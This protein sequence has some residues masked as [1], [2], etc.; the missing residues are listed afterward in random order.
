MAPVTFDDE[1]QIV[2]KINDLLKKIEKTAND[3]VDAINGW[4]NKLPDIFT[5]GIRAATEKFVDLMNRVF[6]AVAEIFTNLGSPATLWHTAD[7]W[8]A[9][10]GGPVSGLSG[11]ADPAQSA[12]LQRWTGTAAD[13]YKETL[14]PQRKAIDAIK[15][16]MT[17]PIS[18]ALSAVARAIWV[19]FAALITGF[20]AL[21]G[22]LIAALGSTAT[23]V[24]LPAA[25]FIAGA[26]ALVFI[27]A[28]YTAGQILRSQ[29]AD[30]NTT[31]VAKLNDNTAFRDGKWPVA[32]ANALTD[33]SLTDDDTDWH[34][35]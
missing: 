4:L 24:G 21:V 26:G 6:A 28:F 3:I 18:T 19:F 27:A 1:S 25:P 12:A 29:C 34:V 16:N 22:A 10:V 15:A 30:S 7:A 32:T 31:L 17:D 9:Q 35:K 14:G 8:S 33:G 11:N 23:I 20:V 2:Q 5:R 13:A